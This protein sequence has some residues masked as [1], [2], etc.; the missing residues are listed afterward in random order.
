MILPGSRQRYVTVLVAGLASTEAPTSCKH[1]LCIPRQQTQ[2]TAAPHSI[3]PAASQ[4]AGPSSQLSCSWECPCPAQGRCSWPVSPAASLRLPLPRAGLPLAAAVFAQVSGMV[5]TPLCCR[6]CCWTCAAWRPVQ[7]VGR[8]LQQ[9]PARLQDEQACLLCA[10]LT[11]VLSLCCRRAAALRKAQ[12]TG[13]LPLQAPGAAPAAV[14]AVHLH[15]SGRS[16][17]PQPL[18]ASRQGPAGAA[19]D[20][21][22][23]ER[24]D[25]R[26]AAGRHLAQVHCRRRALRSV[27]PGLPA[28]LAADYAA[29][30]VPPCP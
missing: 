22:A 1:G 18:S 23:A 10:P 3:R 16:W 6:R 15:W 20:Q 11:L 5:L 30:P 26:L 17:P 14:H 21:P 9:R 28:A 7:P 2:P 29:P 8:P 12:Q 24:R 27:P 19:G 25:T 13:P 4:L